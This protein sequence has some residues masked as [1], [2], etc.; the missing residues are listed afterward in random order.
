MGHFHSVCFHIASSSR[1]I[2]RVGTGNAEPTVL[3]QAPERSQLRTG[4]RVKAA[5]NNVFRRSG[6]FGSRAPIRHAR[7][8]TTPTERGYH[9]SPTPDEAILRLL[10]EKSE[11]EKTLADERNAAQS[12]EEELRSTID[13]IVH[14]NDANKTREHELETSLANAQ[15]LARK[16]DNDHRAALAQLSDAKARETQ[17]HQA[18][19][20]HRQQL[21]S[22]TTDLK[23]LRSFTGDTADPQALLSLFDDINDRVSDL[24]FRFLE[25]LSIGDEPIR[26]SDLAGLAAT[27][28]DSNTWDHLQLF[29]RHCVA[30]ACPI[31]F[32]MVSIFQSVMHSVLDGMVFR[33]FMPIQRMETDPDHSAFL[34]YI[35]SLIRSQE[36]QEYSGRWRSMTYKALN[37]GRDN[38]TLAADLVRVILGVLHEVVS[39]LASSSSGAFASSTMRFHADAVRIV[40]RAL[41]WQDKACGAYCEFDYS[42]YLPPPGAAFLDT[43]MQV[44]EIPATA[45][46]TRSCSIA[47][48]TSMGLKATR[49]VVDPTTGPSRP[50]RILRKAHVVRIPDSMA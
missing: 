45:A 7:T 17:L 21:M 31:D 33:P 19:A 35:Q 25:S 12:R 38:T 41:E 40:T 3:V 9:D 10:Q 23:S 2:S 5:A 37:R 36:S 11:L 50:D 44:Q 49:T 32:V 22:A 47:L 24:S 18:L 8:P 14:A 20:S 26:Q 39:A 42:T 15:A 43:E 34:L 27:R 6:S 13:A 4:A 46:E 30:V 29:L 48:S 1:V 16:R 28:N